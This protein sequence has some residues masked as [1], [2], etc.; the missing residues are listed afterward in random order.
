M[1]NYWQNNTGEAPAVLYFISDGIIVQIHT[2]FVGFGN[3]ENF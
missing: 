3:S 2:N 1:A